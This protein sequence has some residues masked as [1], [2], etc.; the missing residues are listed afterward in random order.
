MLL[1]QL[2][3]LL[4]QLLAPGHSNTIDIVANKVI[5]GG[6]VPTVAAL[7]ALLDGHPGTLFRVKASRWQI[8]AAAPKSIWLRDNRTLL[9][10]GQTVIENPAGALLPSTYVQPGPG[11]KAITGYGALLT[12]SGNNIGVVGGRFEQQPQN[13]SCTWGKPACNFAI[14]IFR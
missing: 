4:L 13:L 7:Q 12:V 1:Q 10:D 3:L 11:G 8:D 5:G 14:D 6:N 9:M 2:L